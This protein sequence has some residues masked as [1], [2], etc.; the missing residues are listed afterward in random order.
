MSTAAAPGA[1]ARAKPAGAAVLDLGQLGG[2]RRGRLD[3][4]AR[5]EHLL[6]LVDLVGLAT[7]VPPQP[8]AA[9]GASVPVAKKT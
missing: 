3:G 5:A 8:S 9:Y 7:L 6:D 1:A 2:R 4:G